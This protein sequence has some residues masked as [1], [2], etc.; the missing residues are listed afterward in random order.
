MHNRTLKDAI[1]G[2]AVADAVG[3]PYE[4]RDR[5]TFCATDMIGYGT[6]NQP[7][8][9]WSDDT[10]MTIATCYSIRHKGCIDTADMLCQFRKWMNKGEFTPHNNTFDIGN[11]TAVALRQGFGCSD[12]YSNG[13]GSLMRIIPLAFLPDVTED[14]IAAVSSVTHAHS[15]SVEACV[16][17]VK[18]A[19]ELM[20]GKSVMESVRKCVAADSYYKKLRIIDSCSE[21]EIRSSGYVVDTFEAAI[22]VLANTDNYRDCVLR[23]VNLGSD[24]DTVAA[25]AG[26]LAGII[27][28]FDSI[29]KKWIKK[30]CSKDIIDSCLF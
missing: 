19:K 13:N 29:P 7:A 16:L 22:W 1:Y 5:G 17:Y 11:T 24:T 10:S 20:T 3:V 30:L 12:E 14:D 18:I 26:G 6:Y 8:G 21:S 4:F 28:G 25:V 9:T 2:L 23:A 15:V 27:Y